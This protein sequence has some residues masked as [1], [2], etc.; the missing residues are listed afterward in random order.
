VSQF[1]SSARK[2]T[3]KTENPEEEAHKRPLSLGII[4]RLMSYTNGI[5]AKRNWLFFHV[6][7]RG[8]T[9][10]LLAWSVSAVINGP[11]MSKDYSGVVLGGIGFL[12]LAMLVHYLLHYRVRLSM[13][14]GEHV[15]HELRRE[16]FNH[17]QRM[18]MRFYDQTKLGS[19]ISRM[20]SDVEAI[21]QGVQ[22][23]LFI[24]MVALIQM[25]V[26]GAIMLWQD[27]PLF[28]A[29]LVFS[30]ILWLINHIFRPRLSSAHREVQTS[31]SRVT[32]TLAESVNG[33]RVTQGFSRQ[34]VNA[35]AFRDV[36]DDHALYHIRA[37]KLRSTFIPMLEFNSQ[38]VQSVLLLLGCWQVVYGGFF[39]VGDSVHGYQ[40]LVV[41]FFLV[42]MFFGPIT[43]LGHLYD[44]ALTAMAGG[45]RLFDMLDQ[46]PDAIDDPDAK[47]LPTIKGHVQFE[48]VTFG[49]LPDK[50]VLFDVNF[51]ALPGQTFALVGQTG[52]GKSSIINLICK[53]YLPQSGTIR[54]D[55]QDLSQCTSESLL[56]QLGIVQQ[57]NFLFTGTVM[58][59]I[60]VGRESATDE[61]VLEAARKLDCLDLLENLPDGLQTQVGERGA[62]LS[63]GQRQLVC[64]TRAMLA[65]PQ[66]LI[67]DEATSSVDTMTEARIQRAL[68]TLLQDRTSFVVAH[69]LSTIRY[70]DQVL[71]LDH[72]KII[73]RGTHIELLEMRGTYSHLYRQF[74]RASE[75]S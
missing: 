67:L 40:S 61:Q 32:A 4:R 33:V 21:R 70:A 39:A 5:K 56:N 27:P 59:N 54:V 18:S 47:P 45:E 43:L 75:G 46:E 12:A 49:Y 1:T 71:V 42:G 31:F 72:G 3:I 51:E 24:S 60:R 44:M 17:L 19:I 8:V 20:I 57:Q 13:E 6:I 38:F 64:F 7:A 68:E 22:N 2:I 50:P 53:F 10:P 35:Q 74:V 52:S 65:D 73:E 34:D 36:V 37:A 9:L 28:L 48:N 41:F 29:I 66:I 63:L 23:V 69:R 55:G 30:P 25:V 58:D 16:L 26:A 62:S 15:V 14:L 11:L